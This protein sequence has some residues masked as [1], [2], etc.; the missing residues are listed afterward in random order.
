MGSTF[1]VRLPNSRASIPE[2]RL[3][4]RRL[5][6]Q[7]VLDRR[8]EE[9]QRKITQLFR[10]PEVLEVVRDETADAE[11][12]QPSVLPL[13]ARLQVLSAATEAEV[14]GEAAPTVTPPE[15]AI[16]SGAERPTL[17]LADDNADM[18]GYLTRLL[19]PDFHVLTATDG[20]QALALATR[21]RPSLI[22]SD[23][24][25]PRMDGYQLLRKLR[26]A[27]ETAHIPIILLTA[28]SAVAHKIQGLDEGADDYLSKP[29]NFLEL[30]ARVRALLRQR[31][32]E[33]M[34][35]DKNEYLAK[36]NF[37]LVLSKKEVFVQTVEAVTFALEAKDTYTHGHSYR[38]AQLAGELGR[39]IKLSEAEVERVRLA[40]LLHDVGK[41]G[42]REGVLNKPGRLTPEEYL[43]IQRHPEI[44][45][46]ILEG[47]R[48]LKDVTRCI[49]YHHEAWDG[50]GYPG[51]LVAREIP[52]ESRVIAVADT[53]DAMTSD[54]AYRKGLGHARAIEEIRNFAGR[55]FDPE[56][57]RAFIRRFETR[58]P[59]FPAFPSAFTT[60]LG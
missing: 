30:K 14:S 3:D 36:L 24:M 56:I 20:E 2:D 1:S 27:E 19:R 48:E 32:L 40:A 52:L 11:P 42:V 16:L 5:Q 15:V 13:P 47:V 31:E 25:M 57:A 53:Y 4:R 9:E 22:I 55:Q 6:K 17:L 46:R 35:A 8:D 26:S 45:A 58:L 44:G 49:R 39:E 37:D 10:D 38:V 28:K 18:I 50:S 59:D 51:K 23:V 41:I 34:L 12:P 7:V 60:G 29:F 54:R 43:E 33:R 21:E